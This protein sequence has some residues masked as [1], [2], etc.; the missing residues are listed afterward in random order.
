LTNRH[1]GLDLFLRSARP[2]LVRGGGPVFAE[3]VI[4]GC[5]TE[6]ERVRPEVPDIGGLRNVFQPVMILNGWIVA[7]HRAM[8]AQGRQAEDTIGVCQ[9]VF[10]RWLRRLPGFAL[11]GLGRLLLSPPVRWFLEAQARRSQQRR[12]AADFVWRVERG[13]AGEV[14]L[15]FDECAVNKW[16]DAQGEQDLKPYCN[17]ADVTYSRLMGMGLD[18]TRTIGLGCDRCSLRFQHG[19]PTLVPPRLEAMFFRRQRSPRV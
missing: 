2:V 8:K 11:R 13:P 9:E 10:D 18:A 7:L 5:R 19:R 15:V 14:S 1:R 6:Y 16:Y 4:E 17:F 12:H 3:R